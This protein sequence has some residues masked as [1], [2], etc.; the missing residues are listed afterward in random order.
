MQVEDLSSD[1]QHHERSPVSQCMLRT[2]PLNRGP[3]D[4]SGALPIG[5]VKMGSVRDRGSENHVD[6]PLGH[7]QST[8][9][10]ANCISGSLNTHTHTH[11]R[12]E[13]WEEMEVGRV[14][15]AGRRKGDDQDI[16]YSCM[17]LSKR[18][19]GVKRD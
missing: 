14:R 19:P 11:A 17:D 16:W 7:E 3:V 4:P 15:S 2:A 9:E 8:T 12:T 6:H 18:E 5:L 1:P 13:S 10:S